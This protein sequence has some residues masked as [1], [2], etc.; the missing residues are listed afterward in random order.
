MGR[1]SLAPPPSL[2]LI[3]PSLITHDW[4]MNHLQPPRQQL[5]LPPA[6]SRHRHRYQKR[7]GC[8]CI[9][10]SLHTSIKKHLRLTIHPRPQDEQPLVRQMGSSPQENG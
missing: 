3:T 6:A 8:Y 5:S 7:R 1:V 10:S 9:S 4:M 2:Q